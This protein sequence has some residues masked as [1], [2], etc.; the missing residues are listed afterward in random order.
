MEISSA[1]QSPV[2]VMASRNAMEQLQIGVMT[3]AL[4]TAKIQAQGVLAMLPKTIPGLNA[5]LGQQLD[6]RA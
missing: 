1:Y 5:H 3:K 4:D 2:D 6:V